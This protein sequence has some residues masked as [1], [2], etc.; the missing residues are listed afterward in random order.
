M[1]DAYAAVKLPKAIPVCG[2]D[3]TSQAKNL[4]HLP[5]WCFHGGI[6]PIVPTRASREMDKAMKAAGSKNRKYTEHPRVKHG[7]S[8]PTWKEKDLI[9]WLFK[10]N[11]YHPIGM[12]RL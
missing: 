10:Q 3:D 12:I 7:S 8:K 2:V 11:H 9:P 1:K 5:I 4:T 6:D